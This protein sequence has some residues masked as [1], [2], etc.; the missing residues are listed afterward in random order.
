MS[1]I[2]REI[3][4]YRGDAAVALIQNDLEL[5]LLTTYI[6]LATQVRVSPSINVVIGF[7]GSLP[8]RYS[9]VIRETL[10]S[11][12]NVR[13]ETGGVVRNERT[14]QSS[15]ATTALFIP[16]GI[17]GPNYQLAGDAVIAPVMNIQQWITSV[18]SS[19]AWRL[20]S[21]QLGAKISWLSRS[22]VQDTQKIER[23]DS[24]ADSVIAEKNSIPP[25]RILITAGFRDSVNR[26]Y[27]SEPRIT[28]NVKNRRLAVLPAVFYDSASAIIPERFK[29]KLDA[30]IDNSSG[31]IGDIDVS[32]SILDVLGISM[33]RQDMSRVIIKSSH[34]E[35]VSKEQQ[36]ELAKGRAESVRNYLISQYQLDPDRIRTVLRAYPEHPSS[37]KT[38]VGR[39]ENRRV[40]LEIV[41]GT[42]VLPIQPDTFAVQSPDVVEGQLSISRVSTVKQ[43]FVSLQVGNKTLNSRIIESPLSS[44]HISF[45]LNES[46]KRAMIQSKNVSIVVSIMDSIDGTLEKRSAPIPVYIQPDDEQPYDEYGIVLFEYNNSRI[47]ELERGTIQEMIKRVPRASKIEI[48]GTAD[49]TGSESVNLRLAS[50]RAE[51]VA[52]EMGLKRGTYNLQSKIIKD[53]SETQPES[54][55]LCRQV[56]VVLKTK[57][58]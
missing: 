40:D 7:G 37:V 26:E 24:K 10:L 31:Q 38:Q 36:E 51:N 19:V 42:Y 32:H 2:T 18:N 12:D 45:S 53:Y 20:T 46:D 39:A 33:Q 16:I 17:E 6:G 25:Q 43:L 27:P 49:N 34:S 9:Y 47:A 13:F 54:R 35:E 4:D 1:T 52:T 3:I 30:I 29:E 56:K 41:D 23:A 57:L 14:G 22:E 28:Y 21:L 58:K 5:K 11:P 8:L 55:M 44:M 48:T 50:Q 15:S